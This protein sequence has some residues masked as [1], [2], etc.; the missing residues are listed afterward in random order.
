MKQVKTSL[1]PRKEGA[2]GGERM[3]LYADDSSFCIWQE[4]PCVTPQPACVPVTSDPGLSP[5]ILRVASPCALT[6][7][8]HLGSESAPIKETNGSFLWQ[9]ED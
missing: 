5:T 2:L 9:R 1:S 4:L 7:S 6:Q 3:W 8:S